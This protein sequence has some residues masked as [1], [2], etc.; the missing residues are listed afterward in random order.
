MA[1]D[2]D[3]SDIL[4]A[5]STNRES[6]WVMDLGN[7]YHL[8]RDR[9]VFSAYATC[10]GRVWMVTNTT[11]RVVGKGSVPFRMANRGS[12]TLTKVK[13]VPILRKN[14]ISIGMLDSKGCNFE[15][16]GGTLK[17][18]K[19]NKE[20]L[21]GR[22]TGG[23]YQLEGSVQTGRVTV[24]H[25][26]SEDPEW[27]KSAGRY[28]EICTEVWPN[29]SGA[30]SAGFQLEVQRKETVDFEEL[31]SNRRRDGVTTT[32]KVNYFAAHQVLGLGHLGEK[33]S[34]TRNC[35]D[36]QLEDI[37][38]PSSGLEEE[39]VEVQLTWMSPSPI[40]KPKPGPALLAL[41]VYLTWGVTLSR[42]GSLARPV[43]LSSNLRDFSDPHLMLLIGMAAIWNRLFFRNWFPRISDAIERFGAAFITE[44]FF[45]V[46]GSFLPPHLAWVPRVCAGFSVVPF[47]RQY[48]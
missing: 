21:W 27:Y 28:F 12:M 16:S 2:E 24:Q 39:I 17:V 29:M 32:R 44:G 5:I 47:I 36:G 3:E 40:A 41:V 48:G 4:L 19:G 31:Y 34:W 14:L 10:E 38:L 1:E 20:M 9:D 46:L 7:T 43:T 33:G 25:E 8:C 23:L 6:D 37:E 18:F 45:V 11:S 22:K 13:H 35:Q 30:T 26:S 15:A 42:V